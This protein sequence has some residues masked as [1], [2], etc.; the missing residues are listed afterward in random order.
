MKLLKNNI[1]K[2]S[3]RYNYRYSDS[4]DGLIEKEMIEW[5][6]THRYLTKEK[7]MQICLWK[8]PRGKRHYENNDEETI[9]EVTKFCFSAETEMAR[10]KP[11]TILNGVSYPVASTI[12][13]FAFPDRY[14]II[15]FRAIWS[16]GWKQPSSYAYEY[17]AKKYCPEIRKIA[18]Q[19]SLDIRTVDKALWQYSKENQ[20]NLPNLD[21]L[22]A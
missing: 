16:L 1:L 13:Y 6:K 18:K 11:L 20:K 21:N 15:D 9:K 3:E 2:Y 22:E 17:Y 7:F 5:L 4:D 19:Y 10:I 12:L 14:P 8:A